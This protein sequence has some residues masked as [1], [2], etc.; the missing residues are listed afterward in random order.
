[1]SKRSPLSRDLWERPYGRFFNLAKGLAEAGHEVHL[2]LLNYKRQIEFTQQRDGIIWHSVNLLPN[3][4]AYY[5]FVK[6]LAEE[7]HTDWLLGFS[8]TYFGICAVSVAG[9]VGAR[10]L[11]DAYDN[12]ESYI[13][14]LKPLHWLWRRALKRASALT[15]AGPGLLD[16]ISVD[17]PRDADNAQVIAMAA[18]PMFCAGN[19][20]A[21]REHLRLPKDKVLIG[22]CGSIFSS[23]GISVLFEAF[24]SLAARNPAVDFVLTGRKNLELNVPENT[25]WLGYLEDKSMVDVFRSLDVL[26][27]VNEDSSFGNY[28]YPV[29]IY[30]A[31]ASGTP[32][33]ASATASTKYV[34]EDYP[35]AL[36][37]AGSSEALQQQLEAFITRPY[38]V[39][40]KGSGWDEQVRCLESLL[41]KAN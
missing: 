31:L 17:R 41:T 29:K 26:V 8:D 36:F 28:S 21:A 33:L 7:A 40:S 10:S 22:Y 25:H 2:V 13:P 14:W 11:I 38:S 20:H 35:E 23:R 39:Q 15:A 4:L 12:Y 9:S 27:A 19:K 37:A 18:D 5:S 3:P 30:E 24:H 6:T 32:V 16:K 34:L 1:M